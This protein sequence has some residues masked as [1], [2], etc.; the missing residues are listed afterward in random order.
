MIITLLSWIYMAA[1]CMPLGCGVYRLLAFLIKPLRQSRH[2]M[3]QS[4]MT[5]IL[6]LTVYAE[7]FSICYRVNML[8]HI[9]MLIA[10]IGSGWWCREELRHMLAEGKSILFSAEGAFYVLFTLVIA[11]YTSRGTFHTDTA[12]YHAQA[13]RIAEEYG[14]IKGV[15]N[16]QLHFGYDSAY[17]V[18][19]ALFTFSWI[20]PVALHT[21]TG[22]LELIVSLYAFRQIHIWSG[23]AGADG[24]KYRRSW[25][26]IMAS[27]AVLLY[28]MINVTGSVSPATDYAAMF[29]ILYAIEAWVVEMVSSRLQMQA[30]KGQNRADVLDEALCHYGLL[31]V[32]ILFMGSMKLSVAVFFV[33]ALYPIWQ[34]IR[35]KRYGMIGIYFGLCMLVFLP[36]LIRNVLISGWLFYPFEQIDL[37]NVSWKVPLAYSLVDSAQ[38][39]VYGKCLYDIKLVN[40]PLQKWLPVWWG[41]IQHYEQTMI[42][43]VILSVPLLF[44]T[45]WMRFRKKTELGSWKVLPELV[46]LYGA[47][48]I[49]FL[50]WFLEAP[51]IR[52][53]LAFILMIP[54]ITIGYFM[55]TCGILQTQN[56]KLAGWYTGGFL[57]FLMVCCYG[58]V[59]D[60]YM[61]NDMVFIKHNVTQ[62]YY[63][64]P[65]KFEEK[66]MDS[67]QMNGNTIYYDADGVLNSYYNCPSTCYKFMLDRTELM[68]K[69]IKDGFRAKKTD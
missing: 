27:A 21:T 44:V 22:F 56:R 69:E 40:E 65:E 7:Y 3:T 1:V 47:L 57:I 35:Q 41:A 2:T 32:M 39:K 9:L 17:L 25:T 49:S 61:M 24:Q 8:C 58:S 53:G 29:M 31:S 13:I 50:V 68:G 51:F 63:I 10:A 45:E 55:D 5:G 54:L 36:F 60:T 38:I 66:K 12:I 11:F 67:T 23:L 28:M 16:L 59:V 15:A 30:C 19:C 18:F 48:W 6:A 4:I 46:F 43:A 33:V 20:L 37:F 14:L 62:D 34:Y 64:W 26:V 42:Y 52:Y